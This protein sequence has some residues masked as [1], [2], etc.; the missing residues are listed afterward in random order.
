MKPT[1]G[2]VTFAVF[3]FVLHIEIGVVS[4][5]ASMQGTDNLLVNPQMERD[6]ISEGRAVPMVSWTEKSRGSFQSVNGWRG[7]YKSTATSVIVDNVVDASGTKWTEVAVGRAATSVRADDFLQVFQIIAWE[8]VAGLRFGTDR[9]SSL[10]ARFKVWS[11]VATTLYFAMNGGSQGADGFATRHIVFKIE[12][13]TADQ[14]KMVSFKN[15]P[16]DV[17]SL[18]GPIGGGSAGLYFQVVAA[19]GPRWQAAELGLWGDGDAIASRSPPNLHLLTDGARF[20][21]TDCSLIASKP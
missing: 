12:M 5:A 10:T 2:A 16:G 3:A 4:Y 20:R 13:E 19:A 6:E 15:V 9:A 18:W 11:N 17:T 21:I 1:A 14:Q 7:A 8:K